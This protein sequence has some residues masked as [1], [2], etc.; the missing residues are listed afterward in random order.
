MRL[1]SSL[2]SA[3]DLFAANNLVEPVGN[4]A[5][6]KYRSVLEIDS[7]NTDADAGIK[8]IEDTILTNLEVALSN[9]VLSAASEWLNKLRV[10]DPEHSKIDEF[11]LQLEE[12]QVSSEILNSDLEANQD[13]QESSQGDLNPTQ[14]DPALVEST[15]AEQSLDDNSDTESQTPVNSESG[16][17]EAV[18]EQPQAITETEQGQDQTQAQDKNQ[19]QDPDPVY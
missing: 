13:D 18:E 10:F 17:T 14:G 15:N 7:T 1:Q 12:I 9:Q 6:E 16:N 5:L 2:Q 8:K 4:N 11:Q 19:E 3:S